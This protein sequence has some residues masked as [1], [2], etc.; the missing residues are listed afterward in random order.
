MIHIALLLKDIHRER[1]N[2][3]V[4]AECPGE[5]RTLYF[6]D[7]GLIFIKTGVPGERLG[8]VLLATGKITPREFEDIPQLLD[9]QRMIGEILVDKRVISQKDLYEAI[10]AQMSLVVI[11]LF[12]RFDI[13]L[14]F[15]PRDRFMDP[16]FEVKMHLPPLIEKGIREMPFH[17]AL[18]DFLGPKV[19]VLGEG[20][21]AESLSDEEKDVL[22]S[23]DGRGTASAAFQKRGGDP[24]I[25]W[26][27]LYLGYC[28]DM[29][30]LRE[31]EPKQEPLRSAAPVSPPPAAP[32]PEGKEAKADYRVLI[33][34]ALEIKQRLPKTDYYQL[35][36]VSRSA[37]DDEIKKAYFRMARKFHPDRFGRSLAPSDKD[38]IDGVFDLVTKAYRILT[39][40]DKKLEYTAGLSSLRPDED[41]DRSGNADLRFRQG[42]TLFNQGRYEE[43]IVLLEEAVRLK[44]GKGD[45]HL[46]LAMAEVKIP[47][48]SRKAERD[49]LKATELEPWNPEGFLGLGLLYKREGLLL[50]AKKQFERALEADSEHRAARQALE[51]MGEKPEGRKGFKRLFNPKNK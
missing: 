51:E 33:E 1:R 20:G 35:L 12:P 37:N 22:A 8:A 4:T 29:V 14:E 50:R 11:R 25:F 7:G 21:A 42:K 38:A 19:P 15:H 26:K 17:P 3:Q 18:A 36:G 49:F 32:A 45:F 34:E 43:A 16:D 44:E 24:G 39:N 13:R 5:Q 6:Q 30:S 23:F 46:L 27:S 48:L 28:L 41:I 2:G 40:K 9:G 31:P 10:L 47:A